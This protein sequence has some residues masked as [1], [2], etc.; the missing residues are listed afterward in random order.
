[1]NSEIIKLPTVALRGIVAFPNT[2]ISFEA[3]RPETVKALETAM[4]GNK[5]LF[6]TA[7]IQSEEEDIKIDNLY[8]IGTIATIQQAMRLPNGIMR[9]IADCSERAVIIAFSDGEYLSC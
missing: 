4:A 7:Q 2:S 1:M 3:A 5:T 8:K 6:L 9:I